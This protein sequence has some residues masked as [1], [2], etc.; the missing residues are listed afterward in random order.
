MPSRGIA[1]SDVYRNSFLRKSSKFP[2][3][4]L[5]IVKFLVSRDITVDLQILY[6]PFWDWF[7]F[8]SSFFLNYISITT[9]HFTK[10]ADRILGEKK[11]YNYKKE[12]KIYLLF[13]MLI[14]MKFC[15]IM[16]HA[17]IVLFKTEKK[18]GIHLWNYW[19]EL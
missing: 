10:N 8:I 19:P 1:M 16:F 7:F 11:Y 2:K 9:Y 12:S 18:I 13:K 15:F 3:L 14:F 17:P 6:K 4:V 5:H